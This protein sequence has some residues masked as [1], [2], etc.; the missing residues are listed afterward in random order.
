MK[1]GYA[2]SFMLVVL[3]VLVDKI[4][5]VKYN[6]FYRIPTVQH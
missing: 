5:W 4:L 1:N 3:L 2:L 6:K